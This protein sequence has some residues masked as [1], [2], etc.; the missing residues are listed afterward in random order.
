[1][2][3]L[4]AYYVSIVPETSKIAPGVKK[5]LSGVDKSA[6]STG[7]GMGSK[8]ATGM[9]SVLK[10]SA[11]G[12][13]IAAGGALGAG[14]AK[15]L[16]RLNSIEQAEAKL[17]GLGHS[18]SDVSAIMKNALASV[19]GTSFGLEEAAS[20]A[21]G[22]VASGVKPGKDLE[23][24]LKIM[25]DTATIAGTN[26]NDMSVIFGSVMARGKLQGDDMLQIMS[27]GVPVLQLLGEELGKTSQEV[28][29]MV[30]KGQIDFETFQSAMER[31]MSGA[32]L[33]AG[34]TVSG[35][36]KNMGAAAGRLGATLAGPFFDQAAGAFGGITNA[37]DSMNDAAGPVMDAFSSRLEKDI[38]PAM[39]RMAAQA[40]ALFESFA[41]SGT[42]ARTA[43]VFSELGAA[44][45]G[46]GPTLGNIA[47]A[48]G[49]ASAALGVSGWN[50]FLTVLEGAGAAAQALTPP[51]ELVSDLMA[52]HPGLVAAAVAA[53]TGFK[54]VPALLDRVSQATAPL[55]AAATNAAELGSQFTAFRRA[56]PEVSR[57]AVAAK[58]LTDTAPGFVNL[59]SATKTAAGGFNLV[60]T[61]VGGL[62]AA[63]GGPLTVGLVA[64]TALI[65]SEKAAVAAAKAAHDRMT[66]AVREGAEA[67][68]ELR[69]A[70]AGT[71][72]ALSEEGLALAAK[73]VRGE[74]AG[75]IEEGSRSL[76]VME[77]ME[78]ATL[79]LDQAL[80]HVPGFFNESGKAAVEATEKQKRLHE[81]Y[82]ALEGAAEDL[83]IPMDSLNDIVA[84]GG[85]EFDRLIARLRNSGDAGN[86]AAD[87]LEAA[88]AK[89]DDM[90]KAAQRLDPAFV[91][92]S[93][94]VN[95]L[96]E[97]GSSAEDK[98][99]SL[100]TVMQAL[101][102][103]PK[104]AEVAMMDAAEAVEELSD[105]AAGAIDESAGLGDAMFDA[106]GKLD[107]ANA[108][109]RALSDSLSEMRSELENVAV[110]GGDT[111]KIF[112]L[113]GPQ[114]EELQ[115]Q[116]HLTD[117][118]MAT[119][120][121]S[122][123]LVPKTIDTLV[124]LDGADET[125]QQLVKVAGALDNVPEGKS[126]E[127]DPLTE[128]AL[129][130]LKDLGYEVEELPDGNVKVTAQDEEAREDLQ[131]L[132]L[133]AADLGGMP[134]NPTV[135]LDD[136]PMRI[137]ASQAKG[138]LDALNLEHPSPQAQLIIDKLLAGKEVSVGELN[139]LAAMS[140]EPHA[141]LEHGLLDAGVN[142]SK[143]Q[144]NDLDVQ[145]PE[146]DAT[147]NNQG[148]RDGVVDSENWLKR[149]FKW[150]GQQIN[151]VLGVS[152]WFSDHGNHAAG[153]RVGEFAAG[154]RLP[155]T[156]PG[157]HTTD[158]ILG[159]DGRGMPTAR[160]DRGEWVINR[161]S[162]QR[163]DA[164]LDAINRDDQRLRDM[165]PA[166]ATG[167]RVEVV[168]QGSREAI[169]RALDEARASAGGSYVWGGTARQ[170]A[171][172]SGFVGRPAWAAQGK[173][174]DQM[175]RMGTT[176]TM[177]AGQWP[178]FK[179]GSDGPFVVGVN[180]EHMAATIDGVSVESG[181]DVGGPSVGKG[182]GAF[183]PQFTH[184]YTLNPAAMVP[185]FDPS[186]T[187]ENATYGSPDSS[188]ET[189]ETEEITYGSAGSTGSTSEGPTPQR[190]SDWV[191]ETVGEGTKEWIKNTTSSYLGDALDVFGLSD[192][193]PS[194][195]RAG[196]KLKSAVEERNRRAEEEREH[197]SSTAD[198]V[199]S[200]SHSVATPSMSS[201]PAVGEYD[202]D[203]GAEQWRPV[204]LN[205]LQRMGLPESDANVT[206]QQIDIESGGDPNA[207]N[208]SD[209]NAMRG[210]PSVGLL[211]V[212]GATFNAMRKQYPEANRGLPNDR[213]DP[214]AN[215]VAALGW[216][217]SRYGGPQEKWPTTAGYGN[218][219][220]V[221]RR[222]RGGKTANDDVA[223]WLAE[224]EFVVNEDGAQGNEEFLD[225]LN[226]SG[227][228]FR[229]AL[230]EAAPEAVRQATRNTT[231]AAITAGVGAA[232]TGLT[233]LGAAV[234]TMSPF[235]TAAG[236]MANVGGT[237]LADAGSMVAA[238]LAGQVTEAGIRMVHAGEDTIRAT[239][240]D[241][242]PSVLGIGT[243]DGVNQAAYAVRQPMQQ[244]AHIAANQAGQEVHVHYQVMNM[245]EA[246]RRERAR[247]AQHA[248]MLAVG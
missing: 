219:G 235:T 146:P 172:C 197:E 165:L 81:S 128:D 45:A 112:E 3:E 117:E 68:E 141:D 222:R 231:R 99:S 151:V 96:A 17:K 127:V 46:L 248:Q 186:P 92:A 244:T 50:L 7:R 173:D 55:K 193:M 179:P 206:I 10:K 136:T 229:S 132:A 44:A 11:I 64:V 94:A 33:A 159:V 21:A 241:F 190:W 116:F 77:N 140:P 148:I 135:F 24:T 103:A 171:D 60:K 66:Q 189:S 2:A 188:S 56:H 183:D 107:P 105:K 207:R 204:V 199:G 152:R 115:S 119:L 170:A 102:L 110:N 202:P 247:A 16:G 83:G 111:G 215:I 157:T 38:V 69:G 245:D 47:S 150:S 6:E 93:D 221:S 9:S 48:L 26:L 57:T 162:S 75:F 195:A 225:A 138:V 80:S 36:F 168:Q 90:V 184:H 191:G 161:R 174:P 13:G 149:L 27:R 113:M 212:I 144:L 177:L 53:W 125:T 133:L 120:I 31:G 164:L 203:A 131:Q 37:L 143:M 39:G 87:E 224:N 236:A 28:S 126:I 166:Y 106:A 233:A 154:G 86:H 234:P 72:G 121:K 84:K 4:S 122:F 139:T 134:I 34:E 158:G 243:P 194:Y 79:G 180:H 20:A 237:A 65:S 213:T 211:Q 51:L 101:G 176:H 25:G 175:G 5:A 124:N 156:G 62:V 41:K 155:V 58:Y 18:A 118:E 30:S 160:V 78:Q 147:L 98:L 97:A 89:V 23:R 70:V 187:I 227:G 114:L 59:G 74:M 88:R 182:D 200:S 15:G 95:T 61:G 35:A 196:F 108:N 238:E 129:A 32:A 232:S 42:V 205:A 198:S 214:L 169:D 226:R 142:V 210:D 71:T 49:E 19:K 63:M 137:S 104:D 240:I 192:E 91:Q 239:E 230:E 109:A 82:E 217:V 228:D 145:H 153:G 100:E 43:D 216:V 12:A 54:T 14:L 167:G 73:V 29:D 67:Q 209:I 123:G 223:A 8:L 185:P 130:R 40:G 246:I 181:G 1:M 178:G 201:S 52:D 22:A 220:Q 85:P 218:G 242:G 76:S 163:Y 208:D